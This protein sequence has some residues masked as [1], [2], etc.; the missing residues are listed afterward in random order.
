MV[1]TAL[2][3]SAMTK[4]N[5]ATY[6]DDKLS[7]QEIADLIVAQW[8]SEQYPTIA[9]VTTAVHKIRQDLPRSVI[10]WLAF[11]TIESD[12]QG[13]SEPATTAWPPR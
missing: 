7:G 13:C 1:K 5:H 6:E 11:H 3:G 2:M 10:F 8:Q 4:Q 9:A 12:I